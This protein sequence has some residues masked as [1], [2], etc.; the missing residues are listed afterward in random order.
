MYV[1]RLACK[2]AVA[3]AGRTIVVFDSHKVVDVV[4]NRCMMEYRIDQCSSE[5]IHAMKDFY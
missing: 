4:A 1:I 2:L 5:I 3:S